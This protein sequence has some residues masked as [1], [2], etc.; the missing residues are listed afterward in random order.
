MS[1]LRNIKNHVQAVRQNGG[2]LA[3]DQL[4]VVTRAAVPTDANLANGRIVYVTGTGFRAYAEGAWFTIPTSTTGVSGS[5]WD[6]IYAGDKSLTINGT[7]L[8]FAGT[9]ASNAVFTVTGAGTGTAIQITNASTGAD[10]TGTSSTWSVSKA[11]AAVFTAVTG[12]NTLTAAANLAI[13]A[14]GAGTIAI[15]NVSTGAVTI[16]PALTAT[17]S[18]T[19]TGTADTDVLVVTNGD[20]TIGGSITM[21]ENDTATWGLNI[22]SSGTSGGAIYATCNDLTSGWICVLDSDNE[23]SF[24]SGGYLRL[25]DGTDSVLTIAAN[26]ATIIAGDAAG[27]DAFTIT[28]GDI[29]LDDSDNNVIESEDGTNNLLVL[30]N[31]AGA[32]GSGKAV[33]V[34]DAGGVVNAAGY[35]ILASFTG[36][37]AAGATVIGVVPDAGSLG[38]KVAP[39]A[40]DTRELLYLDSDPTAYDVAYL[41]SDAVIASDKAVINITSAGAIASGGNVM[42][43]DVTGTPASGAIYTEFDFAGLTDT[44]ENIG[45]LIDAGGKKVRA[46]YIDADPIA[47]DV[48]YV[49]TDAAIADNKAVLS[50]HDAGTPAAAGSN[51]LRVEFA[52]TATNKPTLIEVI[53]GGKDCQSLTIDSDPTTTDV[54]YVHTDGVIA[55]NK[56]VLS[57][58]SAGAQAAGS[59]I[60]R[61]AHAGTPAAATSYTF[62]ID[63]TGSTTTNNA[64]CVRIDNHTSTGAVIQATSAGAAAPL[65]DLYSTNTGATGV[66]VKTTHTSTASAAANDIVASYQMYGLDD[67]NV[68]TEYGRMETKI[69]SPTGG[70][71]SSAMQFYVTVGGT[72]ETALVLKTNYAIVGAGTDHGYIT[73]SGAYNLVLNTNE[74]TNSSSITITD[75]ANGDVSVAVD[76]TGNFNVQNLTYETN[77]GSVVAGT[78]T[79]VWGD[80]EGQVVFCT[81]AGGAYSITLPAAATVG[82]G[83]WYTFIKTDAAANAITIDGNASETIGIPGAAMATTYA[84][85]DAIHDSITIVCDGTSWYI[86][87]KAV[88]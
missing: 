40:V 43:V 38:I 54:V 37:A 59:S 73:S 34:V 42:R 21:T 72:S 23:A 2:I 44:N 66:V 15:G 79:L 55:D 62:E 57:L 60:L 22:T 85:I 76:G 83:G 86:M 69:I 6:D 71:E 4:Q 35:G 27:T 10:I 74:G 1:S 88:S 80:S 17:A 3:T 50:L 75:A 48:V 45:V 67:G 68:A 63:N 51:I 56:A 64:V 87:E 47:N 11:G 82:A 24:T 28:A 39:G 26:G 49:H 13:N 7:T 53:G 19:I 16:T 78:T 46:L 9:H 58:H 18:V 41:H 81:S 61:L 14:T 77:A 36:A 5:T 25:M 30:D 52:G 8:T 33:L 70:A 32:V 29:L 31:K 12:C 84:G 20:M 65:L